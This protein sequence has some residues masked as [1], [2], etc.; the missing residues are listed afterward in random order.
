MRK[1]TFER[2]RNTFTCVKFLTTQHRELQKNISLIHKFS[3]AGKREQAYP[4][5][6]AP[7]LPVYIPQQKAQSQPTYSISQPAQGPHQPDYPGSLAW[8]TAKEF[9]C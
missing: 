7:D 3:H 9:P 1:D 8:L 2:V 5:M 4:Q 6:P